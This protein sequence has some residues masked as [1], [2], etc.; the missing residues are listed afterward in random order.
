MLGESEARCVSRLVGEVARPRFSEAVGSGDVD[1]STLGRLGAGLFRAPDRPRHVRER[2]ILEP[3]R[4]QAARDRRQARRRR[5]SP[6]PL[7]L[8][9]LRPP[10]A[11]ALREPLRRGAQLLEG[12]AGT[13]LPASALEPGAHPSAGGVCGPSPR[14]GSEELRERPYGYGFSA[15]GR[16]LGLR[17][18]A[19]YREAVLAAEARGADPP[20]N[21]FDSSRVQ[22]SS[23]WSTNRPRCAPSRPKHKAA[24][25]GCDPPASPVLDRPR[26]QT[27]RAG[28]PVRAHGKPSARAPPG[29]PGGERHRRA[30]ELTRST[31]KPRPT[32]DRRRPKLRGRSKRW[33][34]T[35]SKLSR[36]STRN[37]RRL[38]L[39][40]VS[41]SGPASRG[42]QSLIARTRVAAT[43]TAT[44]TRFSPEPLFASTTPQMNTGASHAALKRGR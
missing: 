22:D 20:P 27:A 34:A 17:E 23:G 32:L 31:A 43:T 18:R 37:G 2:R 28:N 29:G 8:R 42:R 36:L 26:E 14:D 40:A 16:S 15:E 6:T 24:S 44:C 11:G 4:A 10:P 21:P 39:Q 3:R 33:N 13:R 1:R 19:I 30:G 12:C 38:F 9:R 35:G 5:R 41:G 25:N 7:P